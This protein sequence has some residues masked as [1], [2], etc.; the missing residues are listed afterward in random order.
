MTE[1]EFACTLC[2]NSCDI[3]ATTD[4]TTLIKI[5]GNACKRGIKYVEDELICPTRVVTSSAL[6]LGGDELL[7][8]LRTT[9]PIPVAYAHRLISELKYI[10]IQ[11]PIKIGQVIIRNLYGSGCDVIATRN[12][13]CC[14]GKDL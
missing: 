3:T 4:G 14:S 8:S 6:V 11:A 12:V 13:A 2:P 7:C 1:R 9:K 10:H 5:S